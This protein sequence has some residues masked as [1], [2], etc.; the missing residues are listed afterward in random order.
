MIDLDVFDQATFFKRQ[1]DLI[2]FVFSCLINVVV[3]MINNCTWN[4]AAD[5]SF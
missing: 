2:W 3:N 4:F 1:T 5:F